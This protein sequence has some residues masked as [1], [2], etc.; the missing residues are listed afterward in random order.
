MLRGAVRGSEAYGNGARNDAPDG[1]AGVMVWDSAEITVTDDDSHDN[2]STT[3][4]GAG[5]AFAGGVQR[6]A[7][8]RNTSSGN[9]GPG[10]L[11]HQPAGFRPSEGNTVNRN[12]SVGDG[13]RT[14]AGL[15]L[16][17]PATGTGVKDTDVFLNTVVTDGAG[18]AAVRITDP[19]D[20]AEVHDDVLVARSG[21]ALVDAVGGSDLLRFSRNTCT[22]GEAGFLVLWDG[23]RSTSVDAWRT[24]TGQEATGT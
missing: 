7:L 13:R 4:G 15:E 24:A 10:L 2:R 21:A 9:D 19:V 18:R 12:V 8:S 20:T 1:P 3:S 17:G 22:T 6:S 16:S 23:D 14:G 11:V 5:F